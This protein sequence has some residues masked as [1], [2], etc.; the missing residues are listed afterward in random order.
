M[1]SQYFKCQR[2]GELIKMSWQQ[3]GGMCAPHV[4]FSLSPSYTKF[5][6]KDQ[7]TFDYEICIPCASEIKKRLKETGV[8][9]MQ[10]EN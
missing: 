1:K 10:Y 3:F 4:T 9:E 8:L 7:I 5:R 6:H 2:C